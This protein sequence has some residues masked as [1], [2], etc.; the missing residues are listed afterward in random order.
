MLIKLE[1]Q[2]LTIG[3]LKSGKINENNLNDHESRT[4]NL[5]NIWINNP[6]HVSIKTSG[7][8]GKPKVISL[9]SEVISYSASRSLEFI[10]PNNEYS[11]ALLCLNPEHIGGLMVIIRALLR[12]LDLTIISPSSKL[13]LLPS[14]K[15]DLVSMV[16]L[17]LKSLLEQN[18]NK[19]QQFKTILLGGGPIELHDEKM[20]QK[21]PSIKVYHTYGMT[22]TASHIA[23][24]N[25]SNGEQSFTTLG[26][27]KIDMDDRDCLKI[28]GT[29]TNHRWLQT[30]DVV[31]IIDQSRF[32]WIGRADF[33][34]NSGGIKIHPEMIEASL[35]S[36]I[37]LPFFV[38]GLKDDRLGERLVLL[39]ESD[40]ELMI[41]FSRLGTY[42][43]PKEIIFLPNFSFTPTGKL[44]RKKTLQSIK[45]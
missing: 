14:G 30:N 43:K 20:I 25:I 35:E 3:Q 15:Y 42:E 44:D 18:P 45:S 9:S 28:K 19:L 38:A 40:K 4:L 1:R 27:V 6:D 23:L 32:E 36:Q 17:Q 11:S 8:T 10:D 22:E 31:K 21:S 12:N 24:R 41:D 16:P 26:D 39:V 37:K 29:V 7:S 33:V 5:I 2:K 13:D 34:I